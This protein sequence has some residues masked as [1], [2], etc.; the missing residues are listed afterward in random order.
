[1]HPL[2]LL[3]SVTTR[4]GLLALGWLG[5]VGSTAQLVLDRHW[6]SFWQ[7]PPWLA[8]ILTG[9]A[10]RLTTRGA[11][12][13]RGLARGLAV[14][15]LGVSALGVYMHIE[16]NYQAG[17]LDE[18]FTRTWDSMPRSQRLWTAAT[19]GVGPSPVLASGALAMTALVVLLATVKD[20]NA[21]PT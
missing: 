12:G 20:D 3:E 18:R 7:L 4:Q 10:L 17:P 1:M 19:Q 13:P 6:S 8:L 16:G 9:F 14:A 5:L 21:R 2:D 11:H 15:V